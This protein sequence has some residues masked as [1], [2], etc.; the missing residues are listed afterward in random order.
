MSISI[1]CGEKDLEQRHLRR[2]A[3]LAVAFST[4]ALIAAV[5]TLPALHSYVQ[6]L[7]S[8][9]IVETEYCKSRSRDMLAEMSGL[10]LANVRRLKREWRFGHWM[11]TTENNN[12]EYEHATAAVINP[13]LNVCC[14]CNQ[15]PAG[16]VGPE[17]DPG[18]DGKD[19]ISGK[20][21][22]NGGDA[23][24]KP[25]MHVDLCLICPPGR[26]GVPGN[27]GPKGPPGPKG[28]PGDPPKDGVHGE[29]GTPGQPGAIG[30]PGRTGPP[31]TRG[32]PGRIIYMTGSQGP[33][34]PQGPQG[35]AGPKGIPGPDGQ[36]FPGPPG[37]P[38]ETG[39]PGS[40]G[41][42]GKVGQRGVPGELGERGTCKHCPMKLKAHLAVISESLYNAL[43]APRM[44][45]G[46]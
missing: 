21:G 43:L 7:H 37:L 42:P 12:Q 39:Q 31:G 28:A 4:V 19:G 9:I 23:H 26:P 36:S 15:G 2:L 29:T 32:A 22:K 25:V 1:G 27:M 45:S 14:T 11:P 35:P 44:P 41:R 8:H 40:E 30:R 5:I 33:P 20:D 17:G 3:V 10:Q 46:F 24:L 6:S 38:G 16:P 18:N 13:D 34:G